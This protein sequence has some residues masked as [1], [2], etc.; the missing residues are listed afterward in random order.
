VA[1]IF[2]KKV[3]TMLTKLEAVNE[4]LAAI[5]EDPVA[6]LESGIDDAE[7]A[8]GFLDRISKQVQAKGWHCNTEVFKWTRD[9]NGWCE[10]PDNVLSID[11]VDEDEWINVV[12]KRVEG[13]R[14]LWDLGN[15]SYVFSKNPKVQVIWFYPFDDLTFPLQAYI[16]AHAA[17]RFQSADLSSQV[18]DGFLARDEGEAYAA[19]I[20][21]EAEREDL[22]MIYSNR[23]GNRVASRRGGTY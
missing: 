4:I 16:A 17:Q 11:T 21:D 14:R 2:S 9:I 19:L 18:I 5:G 15:R 22:N 3:N 8:A 12:P 20:D 1:P 13:V 23:Q 10:I 7:A 6:S